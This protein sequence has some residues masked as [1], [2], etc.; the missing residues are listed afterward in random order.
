MDTVQTYISQPN[1]GEGEVVSLPHYVVFDPQTRVVGYLG[2]SLTGLADGVPG[3][4]IAED[5]FNEISQLI[6]QNK[7]VTFNKD[8]S[9]TAEDKPLPPIKQQAQ[10]EYDSIMSQAAQLT[11]MR[12]T[13][14]PKTIAYVEVL[15]DIISGK[16]TTT[17]TLPQAP[18]DL[19]S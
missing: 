12:R 8:G 19:Q 6:S 13:F 5:K 17:T 7:L 18:S 2:I 14:G 10:T 3:T 11:A 16:D 4:P 9:V 1:N 15:E